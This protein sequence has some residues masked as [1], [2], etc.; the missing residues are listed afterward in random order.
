MS[1]T[2][3]DYLNA[4]NTPT[5]KAT[6]NKGEWK[7]DATGR[8]RIVGNVKE[9]EETITLASGLTIPRDKLE[10]Y[11]RRESERRAEE[12]KKKAEKQKSIT[13]QLCPLNSMKKCKREQCPICID[14]KCSI[15]II[16]DSKHNELEVSTQTKKCAFN[17]YNCSSDCALFNKGCAI[18]RIAMS[19]NE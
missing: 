12:Y 17:P 5:P 2:A 11:N 7:T 18:A 15:A 4:L 6:E 1:Y 14:D 3:N 13:T 10:E 16:A 8:Y 19:C 9:Y